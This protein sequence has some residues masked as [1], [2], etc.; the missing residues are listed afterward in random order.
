MNTFLDIAFGLLF[1]QEAFELVQQSQLA[2]PCPGGVGEM[3][4]TPKTQPAAGGP[5]VLCTVVC[6]MGDCRELRPSQAPVHTAPVDTVEVCR[7]V[8]C[9]MQA[10]LLTYSYS[11]YVKDVSPFL[12]GCFLKGL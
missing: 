4:G 6:R 10:C 12:C 9:Q 11:V 2:W 8:I 7:V 3:R 1:Q 5:I